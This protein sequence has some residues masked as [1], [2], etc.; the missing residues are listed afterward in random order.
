MVERRYVFMRLS[1]ENDLSADAVVTGIVK[2]S[3]SSLCTSDSN[4]FD[5]GT[6]FIASLIIL[7]DIPDLA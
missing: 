4:V 1:V 6:V 7:T 2:N 3:F 5:P